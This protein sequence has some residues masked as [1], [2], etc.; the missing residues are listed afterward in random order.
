M[1]R[2]EE[3]LK[4]KLEEAGEGERVKTIIQFDKEEKEKIRAL[5]EEMGIQPEKEIEIMDMMV[6]S[7][8]KEELEKIVK[9]TQKASFYYAERKVK[10][11]EEGE[12]GDSE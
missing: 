12:D 10:T 5:L 7:L 6:V 3:L 1:E 11:M 2:V 8:S 9:G 4:R